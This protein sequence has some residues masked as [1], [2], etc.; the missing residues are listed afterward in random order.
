M[1][2]PS[3]LLKISHQILLKLMG[4]YQ[5]IKTLLYLKLYGFAT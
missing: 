2:N 5:K 3:K 4:L 1:L